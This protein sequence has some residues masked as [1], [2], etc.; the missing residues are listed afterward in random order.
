MP[1]LTWNDAEDIGLALEET[2]P[3]TDPLTLRF[4]ELH[5]MIMSLDG[6]EDDPKASSEA[7]LEAILQAWLDERE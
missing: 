6:F 3:D 5:K 1:T 4:T 7:K 2:H